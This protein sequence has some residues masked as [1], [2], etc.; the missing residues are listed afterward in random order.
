MKDAILE[1]LKII[2]VL[3]ILT[4]TTVCSIAPL[5]LV[6]LTGNLCWL[7][8][9]PVVL[10]TGVWLIKRFLKKGGEG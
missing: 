1:L 10:G 5:Y 9:L 6:A 8:L 4:V 7:I 2:L 3:T